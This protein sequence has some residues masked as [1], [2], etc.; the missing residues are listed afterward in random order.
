MKRKTIFFLIVIGIGIAAG[1][2]YAY[3][4][5]ASDYDGRVHY[6]ATTMPE[7]YYEIIDQLPPTILYGRNDVILPYYQKLWSQDPNNSWLKFQVGM[8]HI[9]YGTTEEG[10]KLLEELEADEQFLRNPKFNTKKKND[11]WSVVDSL[12]NFLALGYLRL[13]EQTNCIMNHNDESCVFPISGGGVHI[14]KDPAAEAIRRYLKLIQEYPDDPLNIWLLNIALQAYGSVPPE[15]PAHL[16]IPRERMPDE[17]N[18]GRFND[19][20][21]D[22]G[23]ENLLDAGGNAVDD[24]DNDGYIDIING[25]ARLKGQIR[26]YRNNADGTFSDWTERAGLIGAYEGLGMMQFDYNNDGWMDFMITR[27]GWKAK[28]GFLPP[29]LYRNN[30]NGTFTDVTVEA[31]LLHFLPSQTA[32]AADIDLDGDLDLFIGHEYHTYS[33]MYLNNG[34]GTFRDVTR[35]TG[36][37]FKGFV[38][39]CSFGDYNNDG[40][41]DLFVSDFGRPNKLFRNNGPGKD[42]LVT[43]T[44]VGKEAGVT[45]PIWSFPC[46]FF[47]YNHDGWEDIYISAYKPGYIINSC[48]E[49]LGL[50]MDSTMFPCLYRNNGDG[51]FTNVARP[52]NVAYETFAMGCNYGDLDNDGWLDFFLSI[53]APDYRAI[54]PNRMYRNNQGKYFQDCTLSGGFGQLQKGHA[55]SYCDFDYDGDQDIYTDYGGFFYGDVFQ[56][57]FYL[58]PGHGNNWINVRLEGTENNRFGVGCRVK[59]TFVDNGQRR[60]TYYTI[61]K[62]ASFGSNPIRLQAGLGKATVVEEMEIIWPKGQK[63]QVFNNVQANRI[64]LCKEDA[65]ELQVLDLKPLVLRSREVMA[66]MG[67]PVQPHSHGHHAHGHQLQGLHLMQH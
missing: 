15:V 45:N 3:K 43:F 54:F 46:W 65:S 9:F 20:A 40:Y 34:D 8:Q 51:T 17:Y 37:F 42:G 36:L 29:S 61:S 35:P 41:P 48:R 59:L 50:P 32:E 38:K 19:I 7:I 58:N 64:Y 11:E 22:L 13:A 44:E 4:K 33:R 66:E 47:D 49:F 52:T 57:A 27:G 56:N 6:T 26:F 12:K 63:K 18:I 67:L 55:V 39:G 60:N 23:V 16:V 31:G 10:L 1:A 62:G 2:V 24:F 14:H 21:T 5:L 53:G 30:G 28:A 25:S